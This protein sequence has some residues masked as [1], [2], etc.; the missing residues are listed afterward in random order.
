MPTLLPIASTKSIKKNRTEN[1]CGTASN[2]DIALG[3]ETKAS[4]ESPDTT[5]LISSEPFSYAKLPK[6]PKIIVAENRD[7]NVSNS[8]TIAASLPQRSLFFH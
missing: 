5:D 8:V 7:V 4:P 2:F 3:Y 1:N 6:I